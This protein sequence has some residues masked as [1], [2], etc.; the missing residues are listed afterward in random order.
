MRNKITKKL[1]VF[2][3]NSQILL[4]FI[5]LNIKCMHE[6]H[7]LNFKSCNIKKKTLK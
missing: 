4:I 5:I 2:Y 3:F 7:D 6:L 1:D